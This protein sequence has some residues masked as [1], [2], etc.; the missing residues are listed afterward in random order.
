MNEFGSWILLILSAALIFFGL[1]GMKI[2]K[3]RQKI[4]KNYGVVLDAKSVYHEK[5]GSGD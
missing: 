1:H 4:S 3:Q 2:A 5:L